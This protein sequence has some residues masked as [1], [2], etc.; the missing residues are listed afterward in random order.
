MLFGILIS[1]RSKHIRNEISSILETVVGIII[2][3]NLLQFSKVPRLICAREDG[4]M[5]F[6]KLEQQENANS[7][8]IVFGFL[9][10]TLSRF[11]QY[12]NAY[13]STIATFCGTIICLSCEMPENAKF[14]IA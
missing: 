2:F 3:F 7:L 8:M 12:S 11:S 4:R 6:F 13:F 5:I 10:S 14:E 9:N 1:S